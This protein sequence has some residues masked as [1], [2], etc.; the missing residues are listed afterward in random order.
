V[1]GNLKPDGGENPDRCRK[2][3]AENPTSFERNVLMSV[4]SPEFLDFASVA[5]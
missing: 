1:G 4:P 3:A 2:K 5:S